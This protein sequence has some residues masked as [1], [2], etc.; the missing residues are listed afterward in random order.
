MPDIS[1]VQ[2]E[3]EEALPAVDKLGGA[4]VGCIPVQSHSLDG[5]RHAV[6]VQKVSA[7]SSRYPRANGIPNKRPL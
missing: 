1:I 3:L 7:T 2:A 4:F 5:Q 6:V